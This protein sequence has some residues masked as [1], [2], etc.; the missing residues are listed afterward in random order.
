VTL[1]AYVRAE[2]IF[3]LRQVETLLEKARKASTYDSIRDSFLI[4]REG[5][6]EVHV[7]GREPGYVKR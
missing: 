3:G 4:G 7:E 1:P 5:M 6:V 2:L